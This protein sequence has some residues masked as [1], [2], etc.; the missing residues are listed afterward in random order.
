[1]GMSQKKRPLNALLAD[2]KKEDSA[3]RKK[4][5]RSVHKMLAGRGADAL[6]IG[7]AVGE[8]DSR[9][10]LLIDLSQS[11]RA[12]PRVGEAWRLGRHAPGLTL[13]RVSGPCLLVAEMRH[14]LNCDWG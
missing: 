13:R 4:L 7:Q 6:E 10:K 12:E 3:R 5:I 8:R 2:E 11:R 1:M 9:T 14:R